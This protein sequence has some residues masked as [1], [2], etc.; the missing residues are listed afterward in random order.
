MITK[1]AFIGAGRW[2]IALALKLGE[3]GIRVT[4]WDTNPQALANLRTSRRHPDLP[5]T[6]ILPETVELALAPAPALNQADLVIFA[7]P[8]DHLAAAAQQNAALITTATK[9][10]VSVTKGIDPASLNRMS[11]VLKKILPDL[12]VVVLA[13]PGIPYNVA[14]GDP[15]SLVAASEHE[16]SAELVRDTFAAGNLRVY[17]SNDVTGVELGAA[18]K[19]VIAIAAGISDGLG[20]GI[21][22][23]AALLTRGL[24]EITRLGLAFN[25]NPLTF[26]G[27]SGMGDLVVTAFSPHS[28]NYQFG[29]LLGKGLSREAAQARLQGVAEGVTTCA[30]GLSLARKMNVAMPIT[31]EVFRI[32]HDNTRPE[33]SID[34]LLR[35]KPKKELWQ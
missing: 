14:L 15:T 7:V 3:R 31:E 1:V 17:S 32:V 22:A 35:R 25:C 16:P 30:S 20:L 5:E 4:L 12:P 11:V 28:R 34:R 2:A 13:G 26:A 19:N 8:S 27:L 9:A 33:E 24:A 29:L 6:A 23:K 21:N 10:I 18:F